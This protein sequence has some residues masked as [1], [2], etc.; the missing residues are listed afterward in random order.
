MHRGTSKSPA[1]PSRWLLPVL[2]LAAF[3]ARAAVEDEKPLERSMKELS[4]LS[5]E[6]LMTLDVS[7]VS[8]QKQKVGQ[9]AAAVSVI[10]GEDIRRSGMTSIPDL[11]RLSPGL[12]V[13][14]VDASRWAIS[15]RGFND[16]FANKLLV[17]MDGRTLYTP[18]F[19]GVYWDTVDYVLPDLQQI[20]V[21][22]G[23]GATLWG[24]NAVNGVIN[25]LTKSARDTQGLLVLGYGGSE[26]QVGSVRYGGKIDDQTYYRV[27]G[28][29]HNVDDAV[30]ADGD[31]AHDGWEALRTGFRID[32]YATDKDTLTLQGDLYG[33]RMGQTTT[34][35]TFT[36]PTFTRRSDEV[37]NQSGGN[38]LARW[39]HVVSPTSDF[40]LQVYYDA[41]R[42]QDPF[43]SYSL[44]TFDADFHHHFELTR[45][46]DLIWGVG[47][48]FQND[49]FSTRNG[50]DFT[51]NSRDAYL[52]NA[53]VQ[54]DVTIVPDHVHL[55]L[56]S[57]FEQ[58]SYSG[59]ELQP[60]ARLLWTPNDRNTFWGA[61]SRAV[62]TPSRAD[63]DSR[64]ALFRTIDPGSGLPVQF[65][66]VGNNQVDSEELTAYELGYRAHVNKSLSVDAAAFYNRYNNLHSL[67]PLAPTF[68][69]SPLPP[70][71]LINAPW[72]NTRRAD[73]YGLELAANW[74]VAPNWRLAA[75]YTWLTLLVHSSSSDRSP[76]P[77]S[78]VEDNVPRNQAQIRSYY[79]ITKD[80]EFNAAAYYVES[81]SAVGVPGYVRVDLGL[82][83]RPRPDVE[84]SVGVQNL[85]DDRHP[86]F[87]GQFATESTEMQRMI[88]GQFTVR[89]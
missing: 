49:Q 68:V 71:L 87:G 41:I 78:G 37:D 65:D 54:D 45:G 21:V 42:R 14:R 66:V 67:R 36:P 63:E 27:Y 3:A 82:T 15:S 7:V 6:D 2:M 74:N 20:E 73:T 24:A 83:W 62:H 11:L 35:S 5:L 85:L 88:Y 48:R 61:V 22:R 58:N 57:K 76:Q 40:A 69:T 46:H 77:E 34:F 55:I 1:S 86:E 89:F 52:V 79:D 32:R 70:H 30:F 56:G 28:K 72:A 8:K 60:S 29:W 51:P 9:A 31:R 19:S 64:I 75:S 4:A 18:A 12:D 16:V 33:E 23:P 39:T 80:L 50:L 26:E 47:A 53:F 25:I 17:L 59:F 44:D 13:A 84:L 38:V 43:G 81:L 10:T